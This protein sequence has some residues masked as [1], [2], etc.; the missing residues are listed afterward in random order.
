MHLELVKEKNKLT[1]KNAEELLET[2]KF[3]S[4]M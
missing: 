2:C 1:Q 4:K 3:V